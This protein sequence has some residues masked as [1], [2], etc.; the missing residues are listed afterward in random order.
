MVSPVMKSGIDQQGDGFDDLD[1]AAPAAEWRRGFDR[2]RLLVSDPFRRKDG[3]RRHGIDENLVGASSSAS[4]FSQPDARRAWQ[5]RPAEI[6]C[7][8]AGR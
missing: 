8:A 5:R 6:P 7:N 4:R 3:T 1:C 2:C